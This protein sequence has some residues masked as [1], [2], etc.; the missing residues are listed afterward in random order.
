VAAC[1]RKTTK[2][3]ETEISIE[4]TVETELPNR[5]GNE[6]GTRVYSST[7]LEVDSDHPTEELGQTLV[8]H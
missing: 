3:D 5:I 8:E 4:V 6:K 2:E 7:Y 1:T